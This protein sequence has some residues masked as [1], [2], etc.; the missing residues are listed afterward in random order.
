MVSN[1][2]YGERR[3]ISANITANPRLI[4]SCLVMFETVTD[5]TVST[6]LAAGGKLE[7]GGW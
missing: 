5:G 7:D 3:E 6:C 4:L 2:R 1:I